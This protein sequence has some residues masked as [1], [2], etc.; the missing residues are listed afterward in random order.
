MTSISRNMNV[1][2]PTTR[3]RLLALK[4]K[5]FVTHHHYRWSLSDLGRKYVIY[6]QEISKG[7]SKGSEPKSKHANEFS[8]NI[9][10]FPQQWNNGYFY[11]QCL[12]AK[13]VIYSTSTDQWHLYYEDATIR[14]SPGKRKITFWIKEQTGFC[15][16]DLM[17]DVFDKFVQYYDLIDRKGFDLDHVVT[18]NNEEFA[19]K[20]GFFARLASYT[21]SNGFRIETPTKSFWVDFSEGLPEEETDDY[22]TAQRMEQLAESAMHTKGDFYDLDKLIQ[23]TGNLVR[24][25]TMR[26]AHDLKLPKLPAEQQLD[27]IQGRPEYI[28]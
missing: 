13:N 16:A 11:L 17:N 21:N 2:K 28:G 12:K 23:I 10:N 3:E 1:S 22:D 9:I 25:E 27:P 4:K 5:G 24:I 19:D 7:G 14:I 20:D 8:V 26:V 18:S 15:Y 6:E